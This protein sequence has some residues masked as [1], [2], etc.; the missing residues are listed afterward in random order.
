MAG[1]PPRIGGARPLDETALPISEL[2]QTPMPGGWARAEA[3]GDVHGSVG[4]PV[5]PMETGAAE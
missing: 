2:K 4:Q 5:I 1:S 3:A